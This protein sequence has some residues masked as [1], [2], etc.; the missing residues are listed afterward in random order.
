MSDA[1]TATVLL[2]EEGSA[3]RGHFQV[4][5]TLRNR[6]IPKYLTT[7]DD[8]A[9]FFNATSA[10]HFKSFFVALSK[11]FDRD[12]RASGVT[13]LKEALRREGHSE[14]A[15]SFEKAIEPLAALVQ[16]IMNVRNRSIAHN[17]RGLP[18][19]KVFEIYGS[20][21]NEI[22]SLID[23]TCSAINDVAQALGISNSI[24]DDDRLERAT[25]EMLEV[26]QKQESLDPQ[27]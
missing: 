1:S 13:H 10:A 16:R 25:L 20:S 23:S 19:D 6:A 26:L 8:H 5:W 14:V 22:R 9:D 18:R 24:F 4:W 3:A 7:M 15:E 2:M 27:P 17:E 11:I 21:P 12:I